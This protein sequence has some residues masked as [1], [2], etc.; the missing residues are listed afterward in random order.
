M[1]HFLHRQHVKPVYV[2][3]GVIPVAILAAVIIATCLSG[4]VCEAEAQEELLLKTGQ[5]NHPILIREHAGWN[6][7]CDA[8][9]HPALY[10]YEPPRHG[11]V[12]ARIENIK[13]HSMYVGTESQCIGRLVRGAQLIY[14]PDAG[15]RW[16]RRPA[17]RCAIP[18]SCQNGLGDRHGDCVFTG[19]AKRGAIQHHT[20]ATNTTVVGAGSRLRRTYLLVLLRHEFLRRDGFAIT[21]LQQGHRGR[22][23]TRAPISRRRMVAIEFGM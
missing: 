18:F 7:D 19:S 14:R 1:W 5:A 13:I 15:L 6:R 2:F 10:L 3:Y 16:Q 20:D 8:I 21:E 9:A 22:L 4:L 23:L 17:I 12:C 11:S